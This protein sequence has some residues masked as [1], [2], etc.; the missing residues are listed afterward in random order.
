MFARKKSVRRP[1]LL[2]ILLALLV[3]AVLAAC[4]S[5]P[6]QPAEQPAAAEEPVAEATEAP[7]A[8]EATAEESPAEEPATEAES[9][10]EAT[11]ALQAFA[12]VSDGTEARFVINE[13]L[14]G[15]D[16]T[17]VG[18]TSDVSG[19][20]RLDPADPA[21]SEIGPITINAR[22]LTTDAD[23][24][25]GAIRRFILQS[26]RD[27]NQYIT[28]TPTS[29]DGM[30]DAVTVGEPFE[31]Q[32]T[33]DLT[34]RDVTRPETFDLSVT[35]ASDIEISGSATTTV[36]YPEYGLSIP[37]VPSVTG[38]EDEVRLEFDFTAVAQ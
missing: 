26:D 9:A 27:E 4:Q 10:T 2:P 34:I 32:V 29:I 24:R 22:D 37:E 18:V 11:G 31:F 16:K 28:F 6:D 30:P 7:A 23:R 38:V 14:M 19:E 17:V 36:L 33:G 3:V 5:A 20:I 25:N 35:P 13:V 21:A 12:I 8:E 1:S 15:N